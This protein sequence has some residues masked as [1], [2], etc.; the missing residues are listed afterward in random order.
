MEASW[1]HFPQSPVDVRTQWG[2]GRGLEAPAINGA[3]LA[4]LCDPSLSDRSGGKTVKADMGPFGT[5][6]LPVDRKDC[7]VP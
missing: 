2:E 1:G 6:G 3:S 5:D 4:G 7:R